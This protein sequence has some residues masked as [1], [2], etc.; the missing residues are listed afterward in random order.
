MLSREL[1]YQTLRK[2]LTHEFFNFLKSTRTGVPLINLCWPRS[3][4]EA[5]MEKKEAQP[6]RASGTEG[7]YTRI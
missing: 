3:R 6:G 5:E 4:Q 7:I 2:L 1:K